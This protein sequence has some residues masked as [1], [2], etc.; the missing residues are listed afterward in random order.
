MN[1]KQQDHRWQVA[2]HE[3][4]VC[5]RIDDVKRFWSSRQLV[6]DPGIRALFIEEGQSVGEVGPGSYTLESLGKMLRFWKRQQSAAILTR[7]EDAILKIKYRS[8]PTIDGLGVYAAIQVAVQMDDVALF[9]R[10]LLGARD[11]FTIDQLKKALNPL[12]AQVLWESVGRLSITDLTSPETREQLDAAMEQ[13]LTI[14]MRRY[15]IRFVAVQ[16]VHLY[17]P[18]YDEHRKEKGQIWLQTQNLENTEQQQEVASQERLL[19]LKQHEKDHEL[20]VLEAHLDVDREESDLQVSKRRIGVRTEMLAALR[21]KHGDTI[22]HK[23]QMAA[24][25]QE[26]NK[27]KLVRQEEMDELT[28]LYEQNQDD[29]DSARQLV[30][31]KLIAERDFELAELREALDHQVRL[32]RLDQEIELAGQTDVKDNLA[33]QQEC[34]RARQESEEHHQQRLVAITQ[35]REQQRE[36]A[37]SYREEEW[38]ALV[39]QKR[40][41]QIKVDVELAEIDR[42]KRVQLLA[43]ELQYAELEAKKHNSEVEA[44]ISKREDLDQLERLQMVQDMNAQTAEREQRMKIELENLQADSAAER[45]LNRINALRDLSS[46]ALIATA[47]SDNAALLADLKKTE[48]ATTGRVDKAEAVADV[49]KEAM[50]SQKEI[51]QTA[52]S[53]P[54]SSMNAGTPPPP[55]ANQW[56]ISVNGQIQGPYSDAQMQQYVAS[57]QVTAQTNVWKQSMGQQ[58]LPA[59]QVPELSHVFASTPPPPPPA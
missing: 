13:A 30:I 28:S 52:M 57:G 3:F 51:M 26:S 24:L 48:A 31:N 42:K 39:H 6:V 45:E 41:E 36:Q 19:E 33:W 47:N 11:T 21:S 5:K 8:I 38:E 50:Q 20:D 37:I 18:E 43:T 29:R 23:D 44:E 34:E 46:E 14:S 16:L 22:D 40:L 35:D 4:A 49:L 32:K 12:I 56:S 25:L 58:W 15:G 2:E 53:Q 55:V 59:A 1:D 10:N 54:G 17:H 7:Q 27:D 9:A